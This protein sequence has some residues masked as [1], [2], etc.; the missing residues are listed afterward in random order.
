MAI[1]DKYQSQHRIIMLRRPATNGICIDCDF[2]QVE[3][4]LFNVVPEHCP[5][6]DKNG[7]LNSI[8]SQI[9]GIH[10]RIKQR[11]VTECQEDLLN[12]VAVLEEFL[13]ICN[14]PSAQTI[15]DAHTYIGQIKAA[16]K[17]KSG[18]VQSFT[19]AL[20][21]ASS[22]EEIAS[23]HVAATL[24]RLGQ[25]YAKGGNIVEAH[26]I[27]NK[28]METYKAASVS[29]HL[30]ADAKRLFDEV[31]QKYRESPESWSMLLRTAATARLAQILE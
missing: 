3:H 15:F 24:H 26:G 10:H 16:Q 19:R 12:A 27:L 25:V 7:M 29:N 22:S 21:I 23:E 13:N 31:D 11:G 28:A 14:Q 8:R 9:Y 1:L 17:D 18:A 20:W 2:D 5:Q 6:Q 30:V 4:F